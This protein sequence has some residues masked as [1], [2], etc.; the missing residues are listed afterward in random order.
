MLADTGPENFP[1]QLAGTVDNTGLAREVSSAGDKT[2]NLDDSLDGAEVSDKGANGSKCIQ[3]AQTG[4]L[5][6]L[7]EGHVR[8][9]FSGV[10][11][12]SVHEG[13]LS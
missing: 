4:G 11:Y 2:H 5:V 13:Q 12:G 6:R 9:D 10:L 1:E 3:S 7:F 8:A